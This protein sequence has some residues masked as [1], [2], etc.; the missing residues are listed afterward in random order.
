MGSVQTFWTVSFYRVWILVTLAG[1]PQHP[2][3]Q[4]F[5]VAVDQRTQ[6]GSA[7]REAGYMLN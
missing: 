3:A 1:S 7:A 4:V 2:R 5:R 6:D